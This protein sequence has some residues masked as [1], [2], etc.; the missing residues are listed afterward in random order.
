MPATDKRASELT[1]PVSIADTDV[2]AGYRPGTGGEPNLDIRASAGL[3]R[4][5]ILAGLA[6]G[7]VAVGGLITAKS[8]GAIADGVTDAAASLAAG[9]LTSDTLVLTPGSYVVSSLIVPTGKTL[10][11]QRGAL[12]QLL[13]T[14]N[15]SDDHAGTTIDVQGIIRMPEAVLGPAGPCAVI[16]DSRATGSAYVYPGATYKS[17]NSIWT[18]VEL[19]TYG[20]L[21]FSV[22]HAMAVSGHKTIDLNGQIDNL[23]AV[24][25]TPRYCFELIGTNDGTDVL[26]H[27]QY[28]NIVNAWLRLL[29]K[30]ILPIPVADIPRV[31]STYGVNRTYRNLYVTRLLTDLAAKMGIPFIDA[32]YDLLDYSN[33]NGDR[34]AALY[35]DG[36]DEIHQGPQG[37]QVIAQRIVTEI[38]SKITI[39]RLGAFA[40]RSPADTFD[41]LRNRGGNWYSNPYFIGTAGTVGTGGTGTAPTGYTASR[42]TGSD[43]F[44]SSVD[45]RADGKPGNWWT[46]TISSPTSG[47]L[48]V[49]LEKTFGTTPYR[50][51]DGTPVVLAFDVMTSGLTLHAS[52]KCEINFNGASP[53]TSYTTG[54]NIYGLAVA[55]SSPAAMAGRVTCGPIAVPAGT[56][57]V[58]VR[59]YAYYTSGSKGV[60]AFG[61]PFF[62]GVY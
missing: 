2:F 35:T 22:Q 43:S 27:V 11:I 49:M 39:P 9:F 31:V 60:I 51:D 28:R 41:N 29:S 44:V 57:N 61:N 46:V 10:I 36:T 30:G 14:A 15:D 53:V 45:A 24:S 59:L 33:T 21:R 58:R 20:A 26:W 47:V 38:G 17:V 50:F 6:A 16:G 25:T 56:T 37:S 12:I 7:D 8:A 5:P 19:L 3:I 42:H 62:G 40:A 34:L 48:G 1:A 4:A 18:H 32:T 55:G 23:F 52:F 54:E 13:P